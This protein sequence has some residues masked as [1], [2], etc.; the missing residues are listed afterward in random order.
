MTTKGRLKSGDLSES[1]IQKAVMEWV[2]LQPTIRDFII[3]IPNEGKRTTSYGKS[4]KDMGMRSGVSDLFIAMPRHDCNGA[5]IELK[6]KNGILR[7]EQRK[8][9]ED[10][11]SQNYFAIT[12][13]S[14][15]SAIGTIEWYCF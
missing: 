1:A 12:C 15:E 8:F 3:H 9:L 2:R 5:W 4:L 7:P 6:S 10:M 11:E 13:F 14:I